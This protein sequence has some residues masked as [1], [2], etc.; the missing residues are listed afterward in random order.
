MN[1]QTGIILH[2]LAF[3]LGVI[4]CALVINYAGWMILLGV[5]LIMWGNNISQVKG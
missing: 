5:L 2:I 4:G 1:R 3:I